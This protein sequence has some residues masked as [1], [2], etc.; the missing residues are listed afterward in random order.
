MILDDP[1]LF[2]LVLLSSAIEL[3]TID[4]LNLQPFR[5]TLRLLCRS[6]RS[7]LDAL[8]TTYRDCCRSREAMLPRAAAACVA[9]LATLALRRLGPL[10]CLQLE[11]LND[12]ALEAVL[13][14]MADEGSGRRLE[15]LSLLRGVFTGSCAYTSSILLPKWEDTPA[16]LLPRLLELELGGC[17]YL[18]DTGIEALTAATPA[19]ARLRV[20]VN[21]LLCRPRLTIPNL[22]YCTLAICANLCDDAVSDLCAGSPMLT[23]L[24]LWRCSSLQSPRF[25]G[26]M[27]ASLN[28]CECTSLQDR[29]L[30]P[31]A[32]SC[33]KLV[34]LLIAGCESLTSTLEAARLPFGGLSADAARA[35][36]APETTP[37]TAHT[38]TAETAVATVAMVMSAAAAAS[39]A[40]SSLTTLDVSDILSMNDVLLSAACVGAP[41]LRHLDF[42]RSGPS[43][44]A[45]AVGGPRLTN[46]VA[47]RC[48][49]LADDAVT[50]ACD[51]SPALATLMLALCGALHTP[52]IHGPRLTDVNLSGCALLQDAAVSH[53]CATRPA[54]PVMSTSQMTFREHP[55]SI[56]VPSECHRRCTHCPRLTRLSLSLCGRL[57]EPIVRGEALRRVELSHC[58]HLAR[59]LIAGRRIEQLSL[60]GCASLE[61][62]PLEEAV[63]ECPS[64][65]KLSIDGCGRL[66]AARLKSASLQT[67][68]CQNVP[69]AVVEAAAD[70]GRLPA[71]HR[72]VSEEQRLAVEVD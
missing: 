31:L 51:A 40:T 32:T 68:S 62:G 2:Y 17:G 4:T 65:A 7:Q 71:L 48:E 14:A 33:P 66:V 29:A 39:P 70:R 18:T 21:A 22:K 25:G 50:N 24:S 3:D 54:P 52:R 59:P 11:G 27:L 8:T 67:L 13:S 53:T 60:S 1:D 42:S 63:R 30:R 10:R 64:L 12:D 35:A 34:T 23:E 61:D 46:L 16:K 49:A 19:L 28:L 43:V 56:R 38:P 45:P 36:T 41:R 44:T 47:T 5:S 58:D 20:T 26:P 37:M 9:N 55:M 6:A 57:V 69:A 72:I 15:S